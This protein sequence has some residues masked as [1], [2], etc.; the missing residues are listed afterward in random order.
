MSHDPVELAY[1]L[2]V[3]L[4]KPYKQ[5]ERKEFLKKHFEPKN[6]DLKACNLKTLLDTQDLI[7]RA[8]ETEILKYPRPKEQIATWNYFLHCAKRLYEINNFLGL[9]AVI[10]GLNSAALSKLKA[11]QNMIKQ[12]P[13]IESLWQRLL[14]F[15]DPLNIKP[16]L[17]AKENVLPNL[18][19]IPRLSVGGAL[20]E[21]AK[22][23]EV[24]SSYVEDP[25]DSSKKTWL[26]WHKLSIIAKCISNIL[27]LSQGV[28]NNYYTYKEIVE[29]PLLFSSSECWAYETATCAIA[30]LRNSKTE[31]EEY[32]VIVETDE[33]GIEELKNDDEDPTGY[34]DISYMWGSKFNELNDREW[35]IIFAATSAVLVKY[36]DEEIIHDPQVE[37]THVYRLVEGQVRIDSGTKE[38]RPFILHAPNSFGAGALLMPNK[39]TVT[40]RFIAKTNVTVW[41]IDAEKLHTLFIDDPSISRKYN[42]S[43]AWK[44]ARRMK[45]ILGTNPMRLSRDVPLDEDSGRSSYLSEQ[46]FKDKA[47][48][49]VFELPAEEIILKEYK[50]EVFFVTY[51]KSSLWITDHYICYYRR[52]TPLKIEISKL[53]EPQISSGTLKLTPTDGV[54]NTK[55]FFKSFVGVELDSVYRFLHALWEREV[56]TM[57]ENVL[58]KA[59]SIF[60]LSGSDITQILPQ[61]SNNMPEDD[62]KLVLKGARTV[63]LHAGAIIDNSERILYRL[64]SGSVLIKLGNRELF[65]LKDGDV[66]GELTFLTGSKIGSYEIVIKENSKLMAIEPYYLNILFQTYPNLAGKFYCWLASVLCERLNVIQTGYI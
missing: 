60:E 13:E 65:T 7:K 30:N 37:T 14:S 34:C 36:H 26:N 53:R 22:T 57:A 56:T 6:R 64:V 50:C 39:K 27:R 16:Y 25:F 38:E 12:N 20:V 33:D 66:F 44:Y 10:S 47:L 23:E 15:T 48:Q 59:G 54:L 4:L 3:M 29:V 32:P 11:I 40:A 49:K 21:I 31:W 58:L 61:W 8:I 41:K 1:Q 62:W 52:K 43:L 17:E 18:P 2:T 5:L 63:V 24:H 42:F 51:L 55:L 19:F 46:E 9:E 35:K 45:R 28:S